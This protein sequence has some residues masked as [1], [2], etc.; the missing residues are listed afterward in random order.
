[1]NTVSQFF[2]HTP[3]WVFALFV[4]LVWRGIRGLKPA[5]VSLPKL[6]LVPVALTVWGSYELIRIYGLAPDAVAIW[7]VG[8][9]CG[10]AIGFL[11]LRH[12]AISVD[13]ARGII[14]RPKD[15]TL[16]P[17]ILAVFVVK[18]A[19]GAVASISPALLMEPLFR[20]AD[21]GLSGLFAGIFIGKFAV[22][23]VR[24]YSAPGVAQS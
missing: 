22:Y 4:Y 21:L 1:M 19:F 10:I 8:L 5:E 14:H 2:I 12:A 16:L 18:Y 7:I 23:A 9:A 13:P 17:L 15:A 11:L 3:W 6:A 20:I 24:Y